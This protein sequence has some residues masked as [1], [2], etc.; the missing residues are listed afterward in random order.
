MYHPAQIFDAVYG[1]VKRQR[2]SIKKEDLYNITD[3]EKEFIK[4]ETISF[5]DEHMK[6]VNGEV[7]WEKCKNEFPNM[8]NSNRFNAK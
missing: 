6:D 1:Y 4:K 7:F 2:T 3:I 8:L 5:F